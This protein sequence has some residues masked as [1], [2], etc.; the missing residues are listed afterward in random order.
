MLNQR[1]QML[2]RAYKIQG[3]RALIRRHVMVSVFVVTMCEANNAA[4][5]SM[6]W[7]QYNRIFWWS[8]CISAFQRT[9]GCVSR[10]WQFEI[11]QRYPW[12]SESPYNLSQQRSMLTRACVWPDVWL[13]T[14][15]E[16]SFVSNVAVVTYWLLSPFILWKRLV[17]RDDAWHKAVRECEWFALWKAVFSLS[18]FGGNF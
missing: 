11:G 5:S 12:H 7:Y 3:E 17:Y 13:L 2:T 6:I 8:R 16:P 1:N 15:Y 9:K 4:W 14:V 18:G 10:F